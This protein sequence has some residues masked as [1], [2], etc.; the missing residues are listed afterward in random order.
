VE[1]SPLTYSVT[2]GPSKGSVSITD[3]D[4]TYTPD[5]DSNGPDS[6]EYV[7]ND[8]TDDSRL[9]LMAMIRWKAVR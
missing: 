8:G 6:F 5:P 3:G 7:A 1:G 2:T 4:F 9:L